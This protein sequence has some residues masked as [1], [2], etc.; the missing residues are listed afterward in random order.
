MTTPLPDPPHPIYTIG[1]SNQTLSAFLDLLAGQQIAVLVD[2]RSQP[3]SKYAPQFNAAAL[4]AGVVAAGYSTCRWARNWAGARRAVSSMMRLGT[5]SIR[6]SSWRRSSWRG[7]PAWKPAGISTASPC[8]AAR[9]I[10]RIATAIC[11]WPACWRRGACL[12]STFAATA[13]C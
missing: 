6:G 2:I 3:Y 9:K 7:S 5:S 13:A 8:C 4:K 10:R 11:W 12:C 1:H